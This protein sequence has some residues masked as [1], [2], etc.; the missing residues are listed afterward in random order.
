MISPR[1][2]VLAVLIV[3]IS[4]IGAVR[5][6]AQTGEVAPQD[7]RPVL[8]RYCVSCHNDRLKTAGLVLSRADLS[9]VAQNPELWEK[10]VGKL[11][12]ASM[13]PIG[14]PRPDNATYDRLASA[15]EHELDRV[16]IA[17]P[18]AGRVPAMHRLN[19]S[20]Y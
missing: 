11:R 19:R 6:V 10:V 7:F 18:N 1:V 16:A 14:L 2:A 5:P 13:P 17:I 4:A 9:Q 20:E 12:S 3:T 15:L 8:D